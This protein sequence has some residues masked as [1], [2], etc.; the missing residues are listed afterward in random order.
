MRA[1]PRA[2]WLALARQWECLRSS[3]SGIEIDFG[4]W[5]DWCALS[6]T[7][8]N[9]YYELDVVL[10]DGQ[11][12]THYFYRLLGDVNGDGTVDQNDLNGTTGARGASR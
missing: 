5:W 11:T 3:I 10:P 7:A 9:G 6:T 8:A 4:V 1:T 2:R 12:A